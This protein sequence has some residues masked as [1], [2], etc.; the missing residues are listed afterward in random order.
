MGRPPLSRTPYSEPPP[1]PL[2]DL[3]NPGVEL[4]AGIELWV[5]GSVGTL[6]TVQV[7]DVVLGRTFGATLVEQLEQTRFHSV[8]IKKWPQ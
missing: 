2:G 8:H 7:P 3:P 4:I 1:R 6:R 5:E